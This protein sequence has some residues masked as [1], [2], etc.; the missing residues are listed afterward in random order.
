MQLIVY[1]GLFDSITI[2][3]IVQNI[4]LRSLYA[5]ERNLPQ[6][7]WR[8]LKTFTVLYQMALPELDLINP[9]FCSPRQM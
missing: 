5:N 1:V 4:S 8:L 7:G 6:K 3:Y 9:L 2:S